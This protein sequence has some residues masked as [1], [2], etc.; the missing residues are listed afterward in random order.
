[1]MGA[2]E[3]DV[4][5]HPP[6]PPTAPTRPVLR[7]LL[8]EDSPS[9]LLL[10]RELFSAAT[11]MLFKVEH[12]GRLQEALERLH[13]EPFDAVLL[14]LGLPDSQGVETFV[15]LHE[16]APD[17]PVLILTALDD[18]E[19]GARVIRGGA[20]EFLVKRQAQNAILRNAVRFTVLRSAVQRER[21]EDR[22]REEQTREL[23]GVDRLTHAGGPAVTARIYSG[24]P[25][26]EHAA[27]EFKAA[28]A[29]YE[30]LL[31]SA[32]ERRL[33]QSEEGCSERLHELGIQLGFLHAGPRDIIEIH[34]SALRK[35][36]AGLPPPKA[37]VLLEEGRIMLLELM[38]H[39]TNYYRGLLLRL[40][41]KG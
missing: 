15:R 33:F 27:D 17:V 8:V 6:T 14:D 35:Q 24:S 40:Q 30:D 38:G 7:V 28:V 25:L 4:T 36:T 23:Q 19:A 29:E 10:T 41:G 2:M 11:G 21:E 22:Q 20:E 18:D 5:R 26:R 12:A 13:A 32:V 16:A 1:M 37:R 34:S 9:D 3:K 39:L 31:G